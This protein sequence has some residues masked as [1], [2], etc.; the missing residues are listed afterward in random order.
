VAD[1]LLHWIQRAAAGDKQAWEALVAQYCPLVWRMLGKFDTLTRTEK[2]DLSHDVFV[3]LL[4]TGLRAFRGTTVHEFRA[5]LKMI[6]VNE[7]KSYLRRHG[8]RL[9]LLD[10]FLVGN[11]EEGESPSAGSF[12]PDPYPGPEEQ[13]AQQERVQG[14]LRC[15]QELPVLE[16]EI[17]W[18][19]VR[20]HSY[21]EMT[22]ML[23]IPQ[24][25][26]A[27]KYYRAKARIEECLRK[28]GFL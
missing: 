14:V 4:D 1:D 16:Q 10:P 11:E 17:F 21:K 18:L 19:E 22:E 9:E 6:T 8:R 3:I 20:G 5:Y 26:V 24:G 12:L 13:T 7:A 25:T 2:E 15:L 28:A 27:S 23:G